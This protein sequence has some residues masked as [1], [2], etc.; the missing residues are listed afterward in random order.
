[1]INN[2]HLAYLKLISLRDIEG[3]EGADSRY[4]DSWMKRGGAGAYFVTVR[5][6][7]RLEEEAKGVNFDIFKAA[8]KYPGKD[9]TLDTI[10]DLRRYL[11]L[12]EAEILLQQGIH[13]DW[14][15]QNKEVIK[16][17]EKR[18]GISA[19]KLDEDVERLKKSL[20]NIGG[21]HNNTAK[22]DQEKP[23]GFDPKED[24]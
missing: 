8:V 17:V 10:R 18:L 13:P 3:L 24:F 16:N 9:G 20:S 2:P 4:G 22:V 7:D 19:P 5:K 6:I 23:F 15:Y 11:M 21:N 12:I 1:M 14:A